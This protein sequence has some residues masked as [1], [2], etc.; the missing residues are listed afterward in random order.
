MDAKDLPRLGPNFTLNVSGT[1]QT[2]G[3]VSSQC[4]GIR[5]ACQNQCYVEIGKAPVTATSAGSSMTSGGGFPDYFAINPGEIVAI[6]WG[7]S[8]TAGVVTVTEIY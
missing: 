5:I 7:P 8:S 3:P 2:V 4:R 1:S 6:I